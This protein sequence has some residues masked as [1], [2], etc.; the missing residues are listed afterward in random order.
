M[1]LRI[2]IQRDGEIL[3]IVKQTWGR[4]NFSVKGK[5]FELN[6]EPI[7]LRAGSI[8][9]HR[10]IRNEKGRELGWDREWLRENVVRRLKRHGAN[11]L[12][13][14]LGMPPQFLLDMCDEEGL[15]GSSGVEFFSWHE[16]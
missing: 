5:G 15:V 2:L 9:W 12:R 4:R 3:D 13:F 1:Q 8:V 16:C 6:G 10:W 11:T 7:H 14:H